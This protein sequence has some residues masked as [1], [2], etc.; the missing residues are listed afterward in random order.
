MDS[1]DVV[2]LYRA[3]CADRLT[4]LQQLYLHHLQQSCG[5]TPASF[6][7][8]SVDWWLRKLST[9]EKAS[10]SLREG[11]L[12]D[13][14][15]QLHFPLLSAWLRDACDDAESVV[16]HCQFFVSVDAKGQIRALSM[17]TGPRKLYL[18]VAGMERGD[19]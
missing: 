2:R 3:L 19:V 15:F 14:G 10:I 17:K 13:C 8:F 6:S 12:L 16:S 18:L 11:L 7:F 4:T 5:V 9:A 1:L